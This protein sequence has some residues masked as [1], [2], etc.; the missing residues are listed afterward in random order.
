MVNNK[1]HKDI[2]I[3]QM[4]FTTH[5]LCVSIIIALS[6]SILFTDPFP[7]SNIV[8]HI[9]TI[10]MIVSTIFGFISYKNKIQKLKE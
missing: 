3:I 10:I 2:A 1:I 6:I 7:F 8:S 5:V 4:K 9:L